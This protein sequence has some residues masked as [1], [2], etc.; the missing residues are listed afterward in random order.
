L[1]AL[2]LAGCR[3]K[4]N[5]ALIPPTPYETQSRITIQL[6][7]VIEDRLAY[8]DRRGIYIITDTKTGREY[9]GVSGIGISEVGSHSSGKTRV[10]DEK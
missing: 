10:E 1:L 2:L 6:I 8:S 9:I 3:P 5:T 7:G 4:Q